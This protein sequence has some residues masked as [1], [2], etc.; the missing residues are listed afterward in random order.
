MFRS[1]RRFATRAAAAALALAFAGAPASA[2]EKIVIS[3]WDG[4]MP[5]DLLENFTKETGIEAEHSV[6]ATNEEIMGKVTAGGGKGYDVLFV[7][8]QFVEALVKLGL[9]A[10]LDHANI[11]NI[12]NLYPEASNLGYD[13][14]NKHSVP[15]AWGTT[16]LCYRS[17]L[18]STPPT[19]W[20]DLLKP[21]DELKG[22][23]TMLATDRWLMG[24]GLKAL[25]HSVNSTDE[26]EIAAAK[27]LL[28]EA[29]KSLLAYDDTTFYSKLVSGE[30]SLVHAWD[31]WCNYGIA[32]NADIK[33]VVPK[34][35][36]DMWVDTMVVTAASENKAAAEAFINYVLRPEVHRWAAENI[37][38]KV[39][40]KAAM[41]S[42]DKSLFET[43]PNMAMTPEEIMQ[44]ELLRDLGNAQ[45]AYTRAVT[46]IT[47]SQ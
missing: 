36:T 26:A 32:E 44:G 14:G 9:V 1:S 18:V 25:G 16:G 40:N 2:A 30:A 38:Y 29:K 21:S 43:Y 47:S 35:G 11:P 10:E 15:Y 33:Y 41:E 27:E 42:V 19:S 39:P 6:H 12:A 37:L 5:A 8:G 13:P 31:G 24:A 22:K 34:E 4:Y 3:N 7:S 23:V 45:K 20:M 28:I 46:E 17:D